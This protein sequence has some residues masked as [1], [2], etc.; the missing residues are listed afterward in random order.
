[1]R[2]ALPALFA[3][4]LCT[5]IGGTHALW[6][7]S[8]PSCPTLLEQYK[9]EMGRHVVPT[10]T[11]DPFVFFLHVPRTAGKTYAHCF[12]RAATPPTKPQA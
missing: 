8:P 3:L 7:L 10:N 1:M 11:S 5:C 12:L 6:G 9:R 2:L 4:L